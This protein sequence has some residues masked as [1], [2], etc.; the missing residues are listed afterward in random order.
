MTVQGAEALQ[1]DSTLSPPLL[2]EMAPYSH[3]SWKLPELNRRVTGFG[4][5]GAHRTEAGYG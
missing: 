3:G 5:F 1:K 4:A 2:I